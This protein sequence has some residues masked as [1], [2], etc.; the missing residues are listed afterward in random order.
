MGIVN[1]IEKPSIIIY[2]SDTSSEAKN[3]LTQVLNGIEEEGVFCTVKE[4]KGDAKTLSQ[5]AAT[6][7]RLEVGIGIDNTQTALSYK[8]M[9]TPMFYEPVHLISR[10]IGTNAA[11][12]AK[13]VPLKI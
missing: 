1:N 5:Q 3:K 13:N 8:R 9:S 4:G 12:L 7:S 10:D 6:E 2:I 11:R